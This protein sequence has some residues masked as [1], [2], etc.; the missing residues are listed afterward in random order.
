MNICR[1]RDRLHTLA[2]GPPVNP[3]VL[4]MVETMSEI[5][6]AEMGRLM[7]L[8]ELMSKMALEIRQML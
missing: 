8:Y 4:A 6:T 7:N 2:L 1:A 3:Q 5:I